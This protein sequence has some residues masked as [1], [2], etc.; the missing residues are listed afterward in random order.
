MLK[1]NKDQKRVLLGIIITIVLF[2]FLMLL[3]PI[4]SKHNLLPSY[5]WRN[6]PLWVIGI[7]I[8]VSITYK[9]STYISKN[10]YP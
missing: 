3:I 8:Y 4:L 5:T 10:V 6:D 1:L 7:A 9:I 2:V